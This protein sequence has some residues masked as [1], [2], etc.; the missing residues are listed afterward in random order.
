MTIITIAVLLFF[1]PQQLSKEE[2]ARGLYNQAL[3]AASMAESDKIL[4][5]IIKEFPT[6]VAATEAIKLRRQHD[7]ERVLAEQEHQRLE[8]RLEQLKE[9]RKQ[10][11]T[12][13]LGGFDVTE[14]T[15]HGLSIPVPNTSVVKRSGANPE[16]ITIETP[17]ADSERAQRFFRTTLDESK[18]K[19]VGGGFSRCWTQLQRE[20]K[21]TER[22]CVDVETYGGKAKLYVTTL[23]DEPKQ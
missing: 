10:Q 15:S 23:S 2:T 16:I 18:W 5:R 14:I 7:A 17:S 12:K 4:E 8:E 3:L 19:P 22:L 20:T 21:R 6:T 9:Q 13:A 1:T 11:R